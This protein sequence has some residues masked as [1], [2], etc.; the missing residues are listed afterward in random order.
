[1]TV[2]PVCT[3][4]QSLMTKSTSRHIRVFDPPEMRTIC[5]L[6]TLALLGMVF[7]D[8]DATLHMAPTPPPVLQYQHHH[9]TD[10]GNAD[11]SFAEEA[12]VGQLVSTFQQLPVG[13]PPRPWPYVTGGPLGNLPRY[14]ALPHA[15]AL[16]IEQ[17]QS[18][19]YFATTMESEA[20]DL[21]DM[22]L[23]IIRVANTPGTFPPNATAQSTVCMMKVGQRSKPTWD[24]LNGTSTKWMNVNFGAGYS[25]TFDSTVS[26]IA[27]PTSN[28]Q[29]FLQ[30]QNCSLL[31]GL[32]G[33]HPGITATFQLNKNAVQQSAQVGGLGAVYTLVVADLFN[34]VN[35]SLVLED[36]R[37][38]VF[39]GGL[40]S[41]STSVATLAATQ[42]GGSPYEYANPQLSI[43][44]G[45]II[46]PN[47]IGAQLIRV[48][49]T[50]ESFA[51]NNLWLDHQFV[52]PDITTP[53]SPSNQPLYTGF[54]TVFTLFDGISMVFTTIYPLNT[55]LLAPPTQQ[56]ASFGSI[57]LPWTTEVQAY[58]Q[59]RMLQVAGLEDFQFHVLPIEIF[60]SPVTGY[61][62]GTHFKLDITRGHSH[63]TFFL[64]YFNP[65]NEIYDYTNP[66]AALTFAEGGVFVFSHA[67]CQPEHLVGF[68]F[69][70]QM[71]RLAN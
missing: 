2:N 11:G 12:L 1:M 40:G 70:D 46:V 53:P 61:R 34:G 3:T 25:H 54:W 55:S 9:H 52:Q 71:G 65:D 37:G 69:V 47:R 44:S 38:T 50:P 16:T 10:G 62:Y 4:N 43:R 49:R 18:R 32:P 17:D 68:G 67:E 26:I 20:G 5:I 23:A 30:L 58:R 33:G 36:R 63:R 19:K 15:F 59:N 27:L 45:S 51:K 60:T 56:I 64:K 41:V 29:F 13:T 48:T 28:L 24:H 7:V 21:Y 8:V 42:H 39:E 22:F 6:A 66:M 31:S 35:V 57:Y 14:L